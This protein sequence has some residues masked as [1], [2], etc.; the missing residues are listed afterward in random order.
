MKICPFCAEEIQD[1]AIVCK[2]CGRDLVAKQP[3]VA[4]TVA[5]VI[6]QQVSTPSNGIAAL[7]S[8]IIPGAGQMYKGHVGAGLVWLIVVVIGYVAFILP[9]LVLHFICILTAAST[10]PAAK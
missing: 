1:A 8:L 6:I 5:P 2:H 7:L 10:A 3:A 9:G 4:T